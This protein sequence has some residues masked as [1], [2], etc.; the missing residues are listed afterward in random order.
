MKRRADIDQAPIWV[1]LL[2]I[3]G[4]V[5]LSVFLFIGWVHEPTHG[6]PMA[7]E[8]VAE[9]E[10]TDN[11]YDYCPDTGYPLAIAVLLTGVAWFLLTYG[12]WFSGLSLGQMIGVVALQEYWGHHRRQ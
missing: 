7:A 4:A 9:C 10:A 1:K 8:T 12:L 6:R 2:I 11:A 5:A 3:Y